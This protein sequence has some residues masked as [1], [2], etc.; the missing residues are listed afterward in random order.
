MNNEEALSKLRERS[1]NIQDCHYDTAATLKNYHYRIGIPLVIL[2]AISASHI[3]T[4][5]EV[6]DLFRSYSKL[7]A[8]CISLLVTILAAMQT[9][10]GFEK[11]SELH[12]KAG[13]KYG[14]MKRKIEIMA[15]CDEK[16]LS[17][18][19]TAWNALTEESPIIPMRLWRK[20]EKKR[21]KKSAIMA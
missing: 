4:E 1:K 9:F 11:R 19:N 18:L 12:Y 6:F 7:T 10:L 21:G 17:E 8:S 5:A 20:N 14:A 3:L 16:N 2:S 15:D 13:V